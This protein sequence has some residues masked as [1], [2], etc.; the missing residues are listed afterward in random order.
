MRLSDE[1][2]FIF[3]H[4]LAAKPSKSHLMDFWRRALIENIAI[5]DSKLADAMSTDNELFHFAYWANEIPDHLED[6]SDKTQAIE[7]AINN[8]IAFRR[9][10]GNALHIDNLGWTMNQIKRFGVNIV[11]VLSKAITIKDNVINDQL[12][13]VRYYRDDQYVADKIR[14]CL[15]TQLIKA[16]Q[17]GKKV[18]LMAH[19][20]GSFISYDVLWRYSHRGEERYQHFRDHKIECFITM[21]SPLGDSTLRN[22]MLIERWRNNLCSENC[23]ARQRFYPMNIKKWYNFSAYGDVVCHDATL[24]DDFFQGMRQDI[25]GYQINDLKDYVR[26]FNPYVGHTGKNNPHK[27]FGY[28]VQPKLSQKLR[29][30]LVN[31]SKGHANQTTSSRTRHHF[32]LAD[33]PV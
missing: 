14:F 2:H 3:I 31:R 15:E 22:F 32:T 23:L 10:A 16:W 11:D 18:I 21:G 19:S 8:L 26:L 30:I 25:E 13:E 4:G 9:Q 24:E 29:E 33:E 5:D 1:F 17:Q 28:L 7:Q 12:R 20:M 6:S 27:S